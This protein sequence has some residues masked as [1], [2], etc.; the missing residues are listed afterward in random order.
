MFFYK[1]QFLKFYM[2]VFLIVLYMIL[3]PILVNK[4]GKNFDQH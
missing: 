2:E 3:S 4:F 1:P